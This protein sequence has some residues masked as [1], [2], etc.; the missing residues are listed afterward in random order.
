MRPSFIP[1]AADGPA[2]VLDISRL[3]SRAARHAPTGIDRVEYEYAI[4][5]RHRL[6][7]RLHYA[8]ALPFGRIRLLPGERARRFIAS[9]GATWREDAGKGRRDSEAFRLALQLFAD[10]ML[11]GGRRLGIEGVSPV[12][13]LVSHRHLHRPQTIEAALRRLGARMVCFI[14]DLIPIEFPEYN[15]PLAA[16]RH[17]L[18]L[19]TAMRCADALIVNSA[20][21]EEAL[22][23]FLP[24]GLRQPPTLVAP[25]GVS[26]SPPAAVPKLPD[27]RPYFLCVS[28][29]E[30]RK[31]HLLLLNIWRRLAAEM[32]P[33]TP[34][35]VLVGRRG[36][37]NEM[38]LD[39]LDRCDALR[40][41][42]VELNDL[43]D[44][45]VQS[46]IA[47]AAA[48]LM[49]SFAEGY[50]LPVAEALAVGT[51][52]I[53]SGLRALREVGGDVPIYLD[54][55]DG[56][57]WMAAIRDFAAPGSPARATQL[58]RLRH[59]SPPSWGSHLESVLAMIAT[60][61]DSAARPV[62]A[63]PRERRAARAFSMEPS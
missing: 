17:R 14:H 61:P 55:L 40:G 41:H 30:P 29:I 18:R 13:L 36:W 31:N 16:A 1:D 57:G 52:A 15:R 5:L 10:T 6:G 21:T 54:P 53:C 43:P 2:V 37:E 12:Y 11:P 62:A 32:G 39:M 38:V 4:G 35:L 49:P 59:W 44:N 60:L 24:A 22:R 50:G 46:L 58:A 56:P 25:L 42:L 45:R 28:T 63:T 51:P 7:D 8:A 23:R 9:I 20:A 3:L 26:A 34:R 27:G 48:L 47:G 33:D 19:D